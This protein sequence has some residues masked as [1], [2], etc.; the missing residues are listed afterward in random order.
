M[1]GS[2]SVVALR[3]GSFGHAARPVRRRCH[4]ARV[5]AAE[6]VAGGLF[7]E[8]TAFGVDRA[9]VLLLLA[10]IVVGEFVQVEVALREGGSCALTLST[11]FAVA[12]I[13]VA[14]LGLVILAQIIPLVVDD[15]KR[16]KHWLKPVFN[17]AQYVLSAAAARWVFCLIDG[18]AFLTPR[19]FRGADVAAAM[20]AAVIYL[21]I[22]MGLVITV[23]TLAGRQWVLGRFW[24]DLR[25]QLTTAG[26]TVAM[27][28][29]FLAVADFSLWLLPLLLVPI[30]AVQVVSRLALEHRDSARHDP[31][32]GLPNRSY[33][34]LQLD[35][36]LAGR[37]SGENAVGVMFIDLDHFKEINDTLGHEAGDA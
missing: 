17:L 5:P 30:G 2:G 12:A 1:A 11:T 23:I 32:T 31:L 19:D 7:V 27:A 37:Q 16:G 33:F 36:T 4:P 6:L 28:P 20:A 13:F 18:Q 8:P 25:Q 9:V 35:Q 3:V 15:L 21:L 22:N 24:V 10:G 34:L 14:P 29:I 26:S